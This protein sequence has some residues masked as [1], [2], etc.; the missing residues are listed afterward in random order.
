[1][2]PDLEELGSWAVEIRENAEPPLV[3]VLDGRRIGLPPV[4]ADMLGRALR[5]RALEVT[6]KRAGDGP[7]NH[8]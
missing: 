8:P 1:M 7:A 6:N 5:E 4:M 3:L 2:T